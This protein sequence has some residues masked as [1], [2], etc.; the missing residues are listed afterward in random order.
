MQKRFILSAC[1]CFVSIMSAASQSGAMTSVSRIDWTKQEFVSSVSFDTVKAGISL[2][3]GK[4][5]ASESMYVKLPALIKD[6]LLSLYVD[7]AKQLGDLILDGTLT[8]KEITDIVYGGKMTSPVFK[9]RTLTLSLT[10]TI[11]V[12]SISGILLRQ[13]TPYVPAVPI[14]SVASRAYS[15]IVIDARGKLPVHGEY[16]RSAASPCFFP[17]I[18]DENMDLIYGRD[19]VSYDAARSSGI[20]LYG[21]ADDVRAYHERIG[22]DPLYIKAYKVYGK[23]RTD[24]V[25]RTDDALRILTVEQ[26]RALLKEGKVVIIL[27]K[28][29]LVHDVSAPLK[30]DSYYAAYD[31]LRRE[32]TGGGD[33]EKNQNGSNGGV[34]DTKVDDGLRGIVISIANV[35]F[36][37]DSTEL[38][39]S[40]KPRIERIASSL[41]EIIKNNDGYTILVEGHTADVGK[42]E[43]QMNLS[44]ERTK[45]IMH[46]LIA[47]GI[48]ASL[49][50][51]RGYGGMLPAASNDTEEGRR[52]NRRVVI[53]VRPKDTYIQRDY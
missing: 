53:T 43:G 33:A 13:R 51:Y 34:P 49:F 7:N 16:V 2:P 30:D 9:G 28:G 27:D 45:T 14:E 26:N 47:D 35:K 22:Y 39:P 48:P 20:V 1:I 31:T 52:Q 17:R 40:E 23:N 12:P 6:P 5:A 44:I 46:A 24:P 38:L 42:P 32:I 36:I 19:M 11:S 50:S 4:N 10:D 37:P 8:M 3:S 15:G 21:E 29:E 18:W 25:I 41:K